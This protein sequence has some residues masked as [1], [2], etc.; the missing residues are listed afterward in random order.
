M[1]EELGIKFGLK[2]HKI[3]EDDLGN[4]AD[5]AF[6]DPC[7]ATNLIPV[8]RDVLAAVYKKAF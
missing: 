1:V 2:N 8:S 5:E 6:L 7:H 3:P 4:L